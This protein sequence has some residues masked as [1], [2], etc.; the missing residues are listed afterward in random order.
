M[1]DSKKKKTDNRIMVRINV[2]SDLD[3]FLD[4]VAG[5]FG[6]SKSGLIV[7]ILSSYVKKEWN[8]SKGNLQF[9]D[10][11]WSEEFKDSLR[12]YY[13][14]YSKLPSGKSLFSDKPTPKDKSTYHI[15]SISFRIPSKLY[16]QLAFYKAKK[17]PNK[18][19][20][21]PITTGLIQSI[22]L[23]TK[24]QYGDQ[25]RSLPNINNYYTYYQSFLGL[26]GSNIDN[27]AKL[28]LLAQAFPNTFKIQ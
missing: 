20:L 26:S 4:E 22:L 18:N 11:D 10:R 8:E 12:S 25:L 24:D 5:K 13:T 15:K 21:I 23:Y 7:L 19:T 2:P 28:A 17:A 6:I 16:D 9:S 14:K 27:I 3:L 1:N